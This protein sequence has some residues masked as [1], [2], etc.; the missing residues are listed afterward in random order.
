MAGQD[1]LQDKVLRIGHMGFVRNEDVLLLVRS[2]GALLQQ[3]KPQDYTQNRVLK[4]ESAA[5]KLLGPEIL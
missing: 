1:H 3:E 5:Q 4:A 2:L